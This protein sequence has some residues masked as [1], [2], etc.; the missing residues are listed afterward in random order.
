MSK[1]ISVI[2]IT[3]MS[4]VILFIVSGFSAIINGSPAKLEAA[5]NGMLEYSIMSDSKINSSG[6]DHGVLASMKSINS[7]MKSK[8]TVHQERYD[9]SNNV[10]HG[11]SLSY[12]LYNE[13]SILNRDLVWVSQVDFCNSNFA[14]VGGNGLIVLNMSKN[15]TLYYP[16]TGSSG[17][18]TYESKNKGNLILGGNNYLN[19]GGLFI[20]NYSLDNATFN[21]LSYML[22]KNWTVSDPKAIQ[23]IGSLAFGNNEMIVAEKF[24]NNSNTFVGLIKNNTFANITN[25]IPNIDGPVE[26]SYGNGS[27]ILLSTN[28]G[29]II[30]P[31]NG[32]VFS[33]PV[34]ISGQSIKYENS[35]ITRDGSD[36]II[37]N[38][39][40]LISYDMSNGRTS[41]L[42]QTS[43]GTVS[44]V[45]Y[46]E[47]SLIFGVYNGSNTEI[48]KDEGGNISKL[49]DLPGQI[50]DAAAS[51]NNSTYAFIGN[52]V[53]GLHSLLYLYSDDSEL[54]FYPEPIHYQPFTDI[55]KSESLRFNIS[56][57]G[58]TGVS[59][60]VMNSTFNITFFDDNSSIHSVEITGEKAS[61]TVILGSS[62]YGYYNFNSNRLAYLVATNIGN[63]TGLFAFEVYDGYITNDTARLINY[64]SQFGLPIVPGNLPSGSVTGISTT[65][66]IP[67]FRQPQP[68]SILINGGFNGNQTD[69]WFGQLGMTFSWGFPTLRAYPIMETFSAH[70]GSIG[71]V[72]DLNYPL[73][74][75]KAYN[76]SIALANNTSWAFTINGHLMDC[77]GFT[78]Y[79]N[80]YGV[81]NGF[82]F[83][84]ET[85]PSYGPTVD[86]IKQIQIPTMFNVRIGNAWVK[87]GSASFE[88]IGENWYNG[89]TT[90]A[91]GT[92]L[93]GIESHLQNISVPN[94]S[95]IFQDNLSSAV[96]SAIPIS[97]T[98]QDPIFGKFYVT[99]VTEGDNGS[100][101][102]MNNTSI[103]IRSI[104][105][106]EIVSIIHFLPAT[107]EVVS[108]DNYILE[109][110]QNLT[111]Q[112]GRN[113]IIAASDL[114]YNLLFETALVAPQPDYNVTFRAVGLPSNVNWSISINGIDR[115]S[116]D[117]YISFALPN[118]SYSYIVGTDNKTYYPP[119]SFGSFV[120]SGRNILLDVSFDPVTYLLI[121]KE[122][123]LSS[124]AVWSV[125]LKGKTFNQSTTNITFSS[126]NSTVAFAEP[127]G[128]YFFTVYLPS[129]FT[130]N[131]SNGTIIVEGAGLT[132]YIAVQQI[133]INSN[134]FIIDSIIAIA[135]AIAIVGTILVMNRR[136]RGH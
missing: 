125:T 54:S 75:G 44:F 46:T 4:F 121:F 19:I 78:G 23:Y 15:V 62:S 133:T 119:Q 77:P 24:T 65:I 22:P 37:A 70:Y 10:S 135:A 124:S 33:V 5:S 7:T 84:L 38:G 6:I 59:F 104:K 66:V 127:N 117:E 50:N 82:N 69:T 16:V 101:L 132:S 113:M 98:F 80:A 110:G 41:V 39:S 131:R 40:A 123:G 11:F 20:Y 53:N 94:D 12:R 45:K 21:D 126:T 79:Y 74:P 1:R 118:G 85:I 64:P 105:Q 36:F 86:I 120:V 57:Y 58:P 17:F 136:N 81:I 112:R 18:I 97:G 49:L 52:Y 61:Y 106:P 90:F 128:S 107:D 100:Y 25:S 56:N 129:G 87:P 14:I 73:T 29:V 103:V 63:N 68:L 60:G 26:T 55:P 51:S 108:D 43:Y 89:N 122:T 109:P 9:Y 42:Y 34:R 93:W 99:P 35:M 13:S 83:G 71:P 48:L 32:S 3:A 102:S 27:F 116:A 72:I 91:Y 134:Y 47:E 92:A 130:T 95:L 96:V 31:D 115:F 88:G 76:F 67:N 111:C 2:K 8:E 28:A 114:H 30:N